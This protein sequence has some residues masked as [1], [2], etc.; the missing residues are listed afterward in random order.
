MS[1][2][3]FNRGGKERCVWEL[4]VVEIPR[5]LPGLVPSGNLSFFNQSHGFFAGLVGW[6]DYSYWES[7]Y[8]DYLDV[9]GS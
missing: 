4:F 3:F 9:R 1:D 7:P 2:F 5:I 8:G 6:K